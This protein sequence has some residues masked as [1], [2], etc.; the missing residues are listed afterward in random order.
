V[1][2]L[3]EGMV[4][5]MN[6]GPEVTGPI[7]IGNPREFTILNLAET[8]KSMINSDSKIIT[9]ELPSD[10]PL[11][12][13]PNIQKA[14]EILGWQPSVDLEQGLQQTIEYFRNLIDNG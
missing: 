10:D 1:D 4:A 2:D 3:I 11:Q 12:R 6:T 8:V 9:K 7:N 14:K 5:L 13:R